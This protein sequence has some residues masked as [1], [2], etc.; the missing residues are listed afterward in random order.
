[1]N[2][3]FDKLV[4]KRKKWVESSKENRFDFESILAGLYNDPSHFIYELLQNAEDEGATKARFVLTENTLDFYHDGKDFDLQDIE[5]VTGIG[6]SKKKDDLNMIG[7]FG[8]GF[9]SVFA[10]T[11]TPYIFSGEYKIKIENF[12]IPV[13]VIDDKKIDETLISLP[14]NH[15]KHSK[16]KIF[17]LISKR[18]ENLELKTML[19]LRNIKEIVWEIPLND[20]KGY[21]SKE[22][23][24]VDKYENV[25]KVTLIS[26]TK[27]AKYLIFENSI[28]IEDKTLKVEVAYKLGKDKTDNEIIVP[29]PDSKLVVYFPTEKVTYLNFVIQGPYKTTPNRE[30]IP[31]DDEQNKLILE[32]T[33]NLVAESLLII[34]ELGYFDINFLNILPIIPENKTKELIYSVI[35]DKVKEKLSQEE[36]LPTYNGKYARAADALLARGKDLTEFLDTEDVGFLFE[37]K[38]WLDSNI[39]QDKN[40]ELKNYLM[41]ELNIP[42]VDFENFARKITAEFMERKSDDWL[43]DFYK[44]LLNQE[45]LWRGSSYSEDTFITKTSSKGSTSFSFTFFSKGILRTKPIIRLENGEHIAPFDSNGKPQ[46]YL[47]TEIKTQYKTVKLILTKNKESLKFLKELGLTEPDLFAEIREFILPKYS[48]ENPKKDEFYFDDFGKLLKGYEDVQSSKKE[49]FIKELSNVSFICAVKNNNPEESCLLKASQI[50][51]GDEDLKNYFNGYCS[52]YFVSEELYEKFGEEKIKKFLKD[53]GVED[54]PRRIEIEKVA[55]LPW[56]KKVRL[57]GYTG[58]DVY[59]TDY[60]YEG[61]D[62]FMNNITPEK[63]YLLWKLLLKS[64]ENLHY[65]EAENFFSGELWWEYRGRQRLLLE[66]KFLTMLKQQPWL[67]D[68]NNNFRKPSDITFSELSENYIKDVPNINIF[69]KVLGFKPDIIEQLPENDRRILEIARKRNISPDEL[70]KILSEREAKS[71]IENESVKQEKEEGIPKYEPGKIQEVEPVKIVTPD[72]SLQRETGSIVAVGHEKRAEEVKEQEKEDE[73]TLIDKKLIGRLGEKCVYEALKNEYEKQG[74]IIE[75]YSGFTVKNVNNEVFEIIWLNKHQD[76]GIGCD[77]VIKKNGDEIEY[78]EVKTKTKEDEELIEVTG[79]QWE[80]ARKLFEQNKGDKY[81]FYIVYPISDTGKSPIKKVKNPIKL[82]KEGKLY[83]HP[84]NF[85][86]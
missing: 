33:A 84:V 52:V 17:E 75:T 31:L 29:E 54:K 55:D 19:F 63:S 74:K 6:S 37:R 16:E 53:L 15:R 57:V 64:I 22:I 56:E 21:Y 77:F 27:I 2:A 58:R 7:K 85:K 18:L 62:N 80:W 3:K 72:L 30:N 8:V 14:F 82:W 59:L 32:E 43:I 38:Y 25:R 12:V 11:E 73:K 4:E 67:I 5:G 68:I 79:T 26:D 20:K 10:I 24:P 66:A 60:E 47:P 36:L 71:K 13:R 46:V 44:R 81:S 51:F 49:E 78:I 1:M 69:K 39:T 61:L 76:E 23:V 34:K 41:K 50:Y 42:E 45:S 70:E 83:A 48:T 65:W 28:E 35:Y 40:P 9:K 86:L